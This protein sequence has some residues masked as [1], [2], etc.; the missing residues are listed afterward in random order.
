MM[1]TVGRLPLGLNERNSG[2]AT[3]EET[4]YSPSARGQN[5]SK[6]LKNSG[7]RGGTT[8]AFSEDEVQLHEGDSK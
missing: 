7:F 3:M 8:L 5:A 6:A 1:R 2:G 4:P